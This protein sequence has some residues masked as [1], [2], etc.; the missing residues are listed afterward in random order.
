MNNDVLFAWLGPADVEAPQKGP[1]AEAIKALEPSEVVLLYA[2][3]SYREGALS[4]QQ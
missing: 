1:V 3:G 2:E 4:S